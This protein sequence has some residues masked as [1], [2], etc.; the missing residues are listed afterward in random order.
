MKNRNLM[1]SAVF[2]ALAMTTESSHAQEL[3]L[4]RVS[5]T[6]GAPQLLSR[7]LTSF[8][9]AAGRD[10]VPCDLDGPLFQ[11]P[12]NGRCAL[13]LQPSNIDGIISLNFPDDNHVHVHYQE[14]DTRVLLKEYP[15]VVAQTFGPYTLY[16]Q[17]VNARNVQ[18][19][20]A[21]HLHP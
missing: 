20:A 1:L 18:R 4:V 10:V 21:D 5:L 9:V 17:R 14:T 16:F 2:M 7:T 12:K 6:E 15:E 13:S 8:T 3:Q 11:S 19:L